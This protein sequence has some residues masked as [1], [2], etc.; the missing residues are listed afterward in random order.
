MVT[1]RIIA[2]AACGQVVEPAQQHTQRISRLIHISWH[3]CFF[4]QVDGTL[5]LTIVLM[6]AQC[7]LPLKLSIQKL[8]NVSNMYCALPH[9]RIM[10]VVKSLLVSSKF[11]CF[12]G[13]HMV[14]WWSSSLNLD[15]DLPLISVLW[16]PLLAFFFHLSPDELCIPL[17]ITSQ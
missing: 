14:D 15:A 10:S 6:K 12:R 9:I 8:G 17:L 16:T 5:S 2:A 4:L 1:Y 7:T 3:T 13:T 11:C